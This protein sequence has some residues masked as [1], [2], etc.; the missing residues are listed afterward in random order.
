ML[1]SFT[2]YLDQWNQQCPDKMWLRER[3]GDDFRDWT[4]AEG[5]R[6]I[7]ALATWQEQHL[8]AH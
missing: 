1:N 7:N 2:E 8:E 3:S 5:H 4:W 6:E